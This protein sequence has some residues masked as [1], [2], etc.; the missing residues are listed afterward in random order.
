MTTYS[1][2]LDDIDLALLP[3]RS[4]SN[5]FL[6]KEHFQFQVIKEH[7]VPEVPELSDVTYTCHICAIN[8]PAAFARE[9]NASVKHETNARIARVA[10]MR[11]HALISSVPPPL[12]AQTGRFCANCATVVDEDHEKT[13]EHRVAVMH[14]NLLSEL[15]KAYVGDDDE[16]KNA[17]NKVDKIETS[18]KKDEQ[19]MKVVEE[20]VNVNNNVVNKAIQLQAE[21]IADNIATKVM[22]PVASS[23]TNDVGAESK[24]EV[25]NK[26]DNPKNTM[27]TNKNATNPPANSV[28]HTTSR[29]VKTLPQTKDATENGGL[30]EIGTMI[31]KN[32]KEIIERKAKAVR[33]PYEKELRKFMDAENQYQ[34]KESHYR[35]FIKMHDDTVN[36][37]SDHFHSFHRI[38]RTDDIEC[39]VCDITFNEEDWEEHKYSL[40][41]MS[42]VVKIGNDGEYVRKVNEIFSHC[43][44]CN[45]KIN[46]LNL[47]KHKQSQHH[48]LRRT[49]NVRSAK[50]K[51]DKTEKNKENN[52]TDK[53]EINDK[54]ST[55]DVNESYEEIEGELRCLVCECRV[56]KDVRNREDHLKGF[57]HLNNLKSKKT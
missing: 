24:D 9:H 16:A 33:A 36:V 20:I 29:W 14:D 3:L 47:S 21:H 28:L 7:T 11:T 40:N 1:I 37:Y 18:D 19:Y 54:K 26:G 8:V 46:N 27:I 30:N 25:L 13:K 35:I 56:P 55:V 23:A 41:H 45:Q 15:M 38:Y 43:I 44:L 12:A 48:K 32:G 39:I 49:N 50:P 51:E 6:K 53:T 52:N 22:P 4:H 57:R 31:N 2:R 10:T 5:D 42:A 34:M 17:D